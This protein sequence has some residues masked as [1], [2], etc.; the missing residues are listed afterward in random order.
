MKK[1]KKTVATT[2]EPMKVGLTVTELDELNDL[3]AD[4]IGDASV[5]EA[6]LDYTPHGDLTEFVQ[7]G[8]VRMARRISDHVARMKEIVNSRTA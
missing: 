2:G 4:I 6:A 1:T 3:S 7:R 8:A 5:L